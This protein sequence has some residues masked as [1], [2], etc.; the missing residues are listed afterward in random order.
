MIRRVVGY[1]TP[2]S[3]ITAR[4][5][6]TVGAAKDILVYVGL[7]SVAIPVPNAPRGA[8]LQD[9][10]F[11]V[12]YTTGSLTFALAK[13]NIGG[14]IHITGYGADD[15]APDL[16]RALSPLGFAYVVAPVPLPLP[17]V[18]LL[19]GLLGFAVLRQTRSG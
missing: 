17:A 7:A 1:A 18:M 11:G 19:T 3:G 2:N 16:L 8:P 6:G 14:L 13:S 9:W 10:L 5:L 4:D 12:L 15:I